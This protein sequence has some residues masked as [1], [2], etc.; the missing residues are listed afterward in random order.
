MRAA[1]AC[2]SALP[3]ALLSTSP[4]LAQA[5]RYIPL[6]R[7]PSGGGG[8]G[9]RFIPHLPFPLGLGDNVVFWIIVVVLGLLYLASLAW[10]EAG[11]GGRGPRSPM[12]GP[13][14]SRPPG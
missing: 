3:V 14:S 5:G 13:K 11:A 10:D 12:A 4:A 1:V 8:G 2:L 7:L 9:G 6:P